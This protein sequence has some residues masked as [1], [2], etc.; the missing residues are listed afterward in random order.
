[1]LEYTKNFGL[2]LAL[3]EKLMWS[4]PSYRDWVRKKKDNS[5]NV[6]YKKIYSIIE[7][8]IMKYQGEENKEVPQEFYQNPGNIWIFWNSGYQGM[9]DIVRI[10]YHRLLEIAEESN[11][12]VNLLSDDNYADYVNIPSKI[13]G[14]IDSRRFPTQL[15]NIIR[16]GVLAK[17]GGLWIDANYFVSTKFPTEW[18][19]PEHSGTIK[20][21]YLDNAI[22]HWGKWSSSVLFAPPGCVTNRFMY[23][24]YLFYFNQY[25]LPID[26]TMQAHMLTIAYDCFD[27]VKEDIDS[28]PDTPNWKHLS[29][30]VNERYD[31]S[32]FEEYCNDFPLHKLTHKKLYQKRDENGNITVYGYLV[33]KYL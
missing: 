19:Y 1:M 14:G 10:C 17:Y 12:V 32:I 9:P 5:R 28:L 16:H 4:S 8:V 33:E 6:I 13:V 3:G 15:S 30:I 31:C 27:A 11:T 22:P 29:D 24:A 26:Y 20:R 7:P 23:D 2:K 18:I 21:L 25:T